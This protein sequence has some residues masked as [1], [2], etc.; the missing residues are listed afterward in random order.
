MNSGTAIAT[1]APRRVLIVLLGAIGDV[2]RALPLLGRMRR[3][4]PQ[5]FIAWT[6][7]P[8]S[9]PIL[10]HHRWLDQLIIYDRK[11]APWSFMQFLAKV[12]AGRF[13]LVIDLQRH[14]K[15]GVISLASGAHE[16]LGFAA[17][18]CKEWN[19]LFSTRRIEPQPRMR[20][21][22]MQ[23]QAFADA[24]GLAPAPVEFGLSL[25]SEERREVTKFLAGTPR[26]LLGIILG[27]SWPSRLY[28]SESAVEV[29][30]LLCSSGEGASLFPVLIGDKDEMAQAS[31]IMSEL[32]HRAVN[33]TGRTTVR[34]LI[35]IFSECAVA[36]GPD[37]GPMHIASALG[38]PTVAIFGATDEEAT[39]PTGVHSRVVREHVECSPCLLRECPIDHRCMT[40]VTADRVVQAAESLVALEKK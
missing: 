6:V 25:D 3:A 26:P 4:W 7:E 34:S 8:K 10:R 21:K 19:N 40:S 35:G 1:P 37:S 32:G 29:V 28:P 22:L 14:L 38:V 20:L 24:L 15:S 5:T 18:N 33:L 27:S 16:R 39:G 2:V 31:Q 36:F 30:R 11:Y 9:E 17:A 23:Y 12:R 13:D